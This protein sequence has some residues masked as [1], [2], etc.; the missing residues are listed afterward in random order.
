[1]ITNCIVQL[2]G[3]NDEAVYGPQAVV[4]RFGY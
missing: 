3:P 1:M 4:E 2:T